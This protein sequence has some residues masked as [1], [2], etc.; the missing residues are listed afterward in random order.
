MVQSEKDIIYKKIYDNRFSIF[1]SSRKEERFLKFLEDNNI[2]F[3]FD[4]SIR[5]VIKYLKNID[6]NCLIDGCN[7]KREFIGIRKENGRRSEFGFK[8][9]CSKECYNKN[10][11]IR[12]RGSN[13]TCHKMS[14]ES[15]KS[16][17]EKNSKIM[18][19][20]INSG[21]FQPQITNSWHKGLSYLIINGE[22]KKYRSSWEA[23]FHLCNPGLCYEDIRIKYI[24][25]DNEHNYIVDFVDYENRILYEVKPES[26]MN[27][28]RNKEKHYYAENWCQE[29]YYTLKYITEEWLSN[30]LSNNI[31]LLKSQPDG[32]NI[33]R[34]LKKYR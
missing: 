13:N 1:N 9:F 3:N 30:N 6:D 32:D 20:K 10:L 31:K 28:N 21:E 14:K 12:Q 7:N 22:K 26:T 24:Y 34:K 33:L 23:F 18:K 29:N 25:K 2:N 17:C 4:I 5:N 19:D 27:N 16:M 11:S 8:K 15:F